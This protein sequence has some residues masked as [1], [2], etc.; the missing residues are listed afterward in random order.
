MKKLT[1]E[2]VY[3]YG[4]RD[5][6]VFLLEAKKLLERYAALGGGTLIQDV[7]DFVDQNYPDKCEITK[8]PALLKKYEIEAPWA[9]Y[10]VFQKEYTQQ[11]KGY[12]K[13]NNASSPQP[14]E[15]T[16]PA[17]T[18]RV[19]K[20]KEPK[21][22]KTTTEKKILMKIFLFFDPVE[23]P[24][25]SSYYSPTNMSGV[26]IIV[27]KD[28]GKSKDEINWILTHE[29]SH[30]NQDYN[31]MMNKFGTEEEQQKYEA[32][33]GHSKALYEK[34]AVVTE[35]LQMLKDLN[36]NDLDGI[37][38]FINRIII[39]RPDYFNINYKDLIKKSY[40]YG[41]SNLNQK[42]N[43]LKNTIPSNIN[44]WQQHGLKLTKQQLSNIYKLFGITQQPQSTQPQQQTQQPQQQA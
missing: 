20:Y 36:L 35:I 42:L 41:V 21:W 33:G 38:K 7:L 3:K 24:Q 18:E 16:T 5:E 13:P 1:R 32:K 28:G 37:I 25:K 34:D 22:Q 10:L 27:I 30:A 26:H 6:I 14:T 29:L 15:P 12:T 40:Q 9:R 8:D 31:T 43:Y 39:D 23:N 19:K 4:T 17:V 44:F 11:I 2:D